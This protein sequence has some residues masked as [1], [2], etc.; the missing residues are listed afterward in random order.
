MAIDPVTNLVPFVLFPISI[1]VTNIGVN[2]WFGGLV[3]IP[4]IS[5]SRVL[6]T[7]A[8][9][10]FTTSNVAVS[11]GHSGILLSSTRSFSLGVLAGDGVDVRWRAFSIDCRSLGDW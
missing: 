1:N 5:S 9:L 2:L 10:R 4:G 6:R 8:S 3:S 7:L 11:L